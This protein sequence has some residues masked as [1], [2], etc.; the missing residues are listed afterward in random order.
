MLRDVGG[1]GAS[2]VV[3]ESVHGVKECRDNVHSHNGCLGK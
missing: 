1:G 2:E 3:V